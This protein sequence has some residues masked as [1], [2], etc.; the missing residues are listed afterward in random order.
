MLALVLHF[1]HTWSR[2]SGDGGNEQG[3]GGRSKGRREGA[4]EGGKEQGKEGW[5]RAGG[6]EQG[7][8]ERINRRKSSRE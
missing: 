3:K 7:N 2:R 5:R 6:K 4:R 8:G 1:L